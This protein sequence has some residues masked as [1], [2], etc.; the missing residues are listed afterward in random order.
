MNRCTGHCC[1]NFHI[2][3]RQELAILADR[4]NEDALKVW[5][6]VIPLG[7]DNY[8]C[9]HHDAATGNCLNYENRP[10]MCSQFPY[11]RQCPRQG[12]TLKS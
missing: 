6:M 7:H 11:G 3:P 12:C 4:G 2:D 5:N 10:D 9:I 1:V 8:N